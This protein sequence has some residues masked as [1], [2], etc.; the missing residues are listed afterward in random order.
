MKFRGADGKEKFSVCTA[1]CGKLNR[2]SIL[3]SRMYSSLMCITAGILA[4]AGWKTPIAC[5]PGAICASGPHPAIPERPEVLVEY[6]TLCRLPGM[7]KSLYDRFKA[8][9]QRWRH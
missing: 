1:A 6:R 9:D 4:T 3:E 8:R 2:K 5:T 7:A